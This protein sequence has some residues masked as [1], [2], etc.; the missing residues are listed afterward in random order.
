MNT[1]PHHKRQVEAKEEDAMQTNET[2]VTRDWLTV[3][4]MQRLLNIG[5]TKSY[6]LIAMGQIP[7]VRI[8]RSIRINRRRLE[9]WLDQQ[10]STPY[11]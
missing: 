5:S 7:C 4:E 8:G 1:V 2:N 9:E 10:S 11:G 3:Q 6:E